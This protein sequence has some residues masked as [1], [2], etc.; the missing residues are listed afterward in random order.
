MGSS[1]NVDLGKIRQI[2]IRSYFDAI[3]PKELSANLT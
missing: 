3:R 1:R 2:R